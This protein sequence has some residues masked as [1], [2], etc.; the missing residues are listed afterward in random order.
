MNK[1]AFVFTI[2][3]II[4]LTVLMFS[5][6][7]THSYSLRDRSLVIGER[8]RSIDYFISDL[9]QDIRRGAFIAGFRALL[10]LQQHITAQGA[11]LNDTQAAFKEV[12]INGTIE[13]E[14][15]SI[16]NETELVVW[17]DRMQQEADKLGIIFD[18][19]IDGVRIFHANPWVVT[20]QLNIS[21]NVTDRQGTATWER[22]SVIYSLV[23]ITDFEDPLYTVYTGGRVANSIRKTNISDFTDGTDTDNLMYHIDN[24]LYISS[25]SAPSYIDRLSGELNASP[26]GIESIVNLNRFESVQLPLKNKTCVDYIYFSDLEPQSWLI[27][28]TYNW[29][30]LDNES[31]HL[32]I[33]EAGHLIIT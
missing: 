2:T 17:I 13:D 5:M 12:F 19:R 1:K 23:N 6:K 33:Y 3:S 28:G 32:G 21:M 22:T 18:Y 15:L 7:I 16:M 24:D 10:G 14:P 4:F 20:I 31:N 30:R 11:F 27:N 25:P 8:V 29:L 26:S 9:E